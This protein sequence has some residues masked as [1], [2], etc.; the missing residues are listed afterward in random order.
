[1]NDVLLQIGANRVA[2]QWVRRLGLPLPLPQTLRRA[3]GA[4]QAR[5]LAGQLVVSGAAPGS[6]DAALTQEIAGTL[7]SAGAEVGVIG[8][9]LELHRTVGEAYGRSPR[10]L[11]SAAIEDLH[12]DALVFDAAGLGGPSE[13]DTLYDFFHALVPRLARCGRV[14]LIG[15]PPSAAATAGQA[16][17]Q[18]ALEGFTRSLAKEVGRKGATA[19]LLV[20]YPG[21]EGR[22]GPVLRF[23]L[24]SR[25]TFVTAQPFAIHDRVRQSDDA[26]S[27]FVRALDGKVALVTGAGR[28]IGEASARALA[29]EGAHVVCVDRPGEEQLIEALARS[30]GGS[31][32]PS[33]VSDDS[34]PQVIARTLEEQHRGVDIVVHN[35][36]ITRDKTLARMDRDQWHQTIDINLAAVMR[37]DDALLSS[38]LLHD[39]GRLIGLASVAG[40]G[41][42]AG[43]T[44][45][46][47]SKAGV[48]GYMQQRARELAGRGITA[49]A[50]APGFIETRLTAAMPPVVRE[51]AR[52]LS[53]LGQ[54]GQSSDVAEAITFLASPGASGMSGAVLRVCGGALLGA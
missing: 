49:N 8:H 54:G 11:E 42:N 12:A 29:A 38:R 14:V 2:R 15:S 31:A 46:A 36:G 22:L 50:V 26:A 20:R 27:G 9:A 40:I 6:A 51:G 44:N 16:A 48:I 32:L 21:S 17:A 41:G 47:A 28:G 25:S 1:M 52:R 5:P 19:N 4:L 33:D 35:A 53:A 18:A 39:D 13:L 34:A 10:A 37:I 45:Y 24:S 43:Q 23:V 3:H 30:I 7:F